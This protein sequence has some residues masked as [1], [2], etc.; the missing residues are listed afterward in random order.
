MADLIGG[1][2]ALAVK[3]GSLLQAFVIDQRRKSARLT[4]V[5]HQA[6]NLLLGLNRESG[7]R[8]AGGGDRPTDDMPFAGNRRLRKRLRER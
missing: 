3:A 8:L 4:L 7:R 6:K 5:V 1:G 2:H